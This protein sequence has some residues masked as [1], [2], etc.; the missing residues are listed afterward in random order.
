M[1]CPHCN[2]AELQLIPEQHPYNIEHLMCLSCYSTF[3]LE[4][5]VGQEFTRLANSKSKC[6][7]SGY[8]SG[9]CEYCANKIK[10]FYENNRM[11]RSI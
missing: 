7:C 2:K 8:Q 5:A 11:S 9:L 10:E 6:T 3:T 4:G 1:I